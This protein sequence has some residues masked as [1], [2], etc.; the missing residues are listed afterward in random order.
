MYVHS[1]SN[2][3]GCTAQYLPFLKSIF[4]HLFP[5]MLH[6]QTFVSNFRSHCLAC[7]LN[8]LCSDAGSS[9]TIELDETA[10]Q[11][12]YHQYICYRLSFLHLSFVVFF[13]PSA[14][15]TLAVHTAWLP[16]FFRNYFLTPTVFGSRMDFKLLVLFGSL[17]LCSQYGKLIVFSSSSPS[18][19]VS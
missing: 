4:P 1:Y 16:G 12:C 5:C 19:L 11:C 2:P 15:W 17:D 9:V 7:W 3:L 8:A 14:Y 13:F 18:S 6:V 10:F